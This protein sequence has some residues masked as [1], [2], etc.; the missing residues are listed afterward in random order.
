MSRP[1]LMIPGPV[2]VDETV[3][4]ALGQPP[5][6]HTAASFIEIFGACLDALREVFRAPDGQ[7]FVV[8]GSGTLAMEMAVANLIEPGDRAVVVDTGYFSHRMAD[9][10]ARHG[11][12][13]ESVSAPAGDCPSLERVESALKAGAKVLAITHVDT[14]TGVLA[15]V[16]DLAALARRYNALTVVDGVCALGGETFEMQA[17]DVDVC[18]TASQ[19]A[20][21]VPPGLALVMA[22][23]RAIEA[24]EARRRP[25][26]SY[27]CDWDLWLPIMHA[28]QARKPS[29]FGTPPT[30]LIVALYESVKQIL[31]EGMEARWARHRKLGASMRAAMQALGLKWVPARPDLCA[32]TLT[33]IYYPDGVDDTLV[34]RIGQHGVAVAGGLHPDIKGRY[35]RIGHMGILCDAE[36]RQTVAAVEAAL[37]DAGYLGE[38]GAGVTASQAAYEHA[39]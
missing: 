33:T 36:I 38:N 24:F 19:K 14:S 5:L 20:L 2:E 16:P 3:L 10:L 30:N 26:G 25:A 22:G 6:S 37:K 35:F 32:D 29:Y 34:G 27:Y 4:Q 18:L 31:K 23:P 8:A 21:A 28:Y 9:V 17:W 1:L 15:P 13:L 11:A 39:R 12:V 7:P